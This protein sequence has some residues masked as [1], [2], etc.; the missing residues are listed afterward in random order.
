MLIS[1]ISD[2]NLPVVEN[3]RRYLDLEHV[4]LPVVHNATVR[5]NHKIL[6]WLKMLLCTILFAYSTSCLESFGTRNNEDHHTPKLLSN[7]D[8]GSEKHSELGLTQDDSG[9]DGILADK[10][11][12]YNPDYEM[13]CQGPMVMNGPRETMV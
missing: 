6:I 4:E 12:N 3:P 1:G 8:S 7:E 10:P 5:A 13:D 9:W 2:F 11:D